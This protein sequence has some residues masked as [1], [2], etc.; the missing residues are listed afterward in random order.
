[1]AHWIR[2]SC[3]TNSGYGKRQNDRMLPFVI[4]RAVTSVAMACACAPTGLVLRCRLDD[5]EHDGLASLAATEVATLADGTRV[6]RGPWQEAR[7][8]APRDLVS[9]EP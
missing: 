3:G 2:C 5:T 8:A 1:M 6:S 9:G 4:D 7:P